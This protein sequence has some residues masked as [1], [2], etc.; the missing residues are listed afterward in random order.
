MTKIRLTYTLT[1]GRNSQIIWALILPAFI[2]QVPLLLTIEYL[3]PLLP[4]SE[5]TPIAVSMIYFGLVLWVTLKWVKTTTA[6]VDIV[7][8]NNNI[9]FAFSKKNIFHRNDFSLSFN[10]ILNLS[11]DF[12]KGFDFIYFATTHPVYNKFHITAK[13][14]N[15]DFADFSNKIF[16]MQA[17]YNAQPSRERVITNKTIYQ[18]WPMKLAALFI[19]LILFAYPIVSFY[20]QMDWYIE[21]KYWVFMALSFPLIVKVYNQ[22]FGRK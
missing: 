22:N 17:A 6:R 9:E 15:A 19:L 1:F 11:E 3:L 10:E 14:D 21:V 16:E 20:K 2:L 13:E 5:W 4:D 8:N 18:K 12:D 7:I